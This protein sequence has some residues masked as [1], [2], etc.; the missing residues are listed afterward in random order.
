[1]A[2]IVPFCLL[3]NEVDNKVI[4]DLNL[5]KVVLELESRKLVGKLCK[6]FEISDDKEIIKKE[7]KELIYEF[8]RDIVDLLIN[9]KIIFQITDPK[10]G[11]FDARK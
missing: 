1:M 8:S 10:K 2:R 9:G 7:C 5:F 6:R 11:E 4:L 3:E